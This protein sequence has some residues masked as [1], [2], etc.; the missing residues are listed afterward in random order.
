M[1]MGFLQ[2]LTWFTHR[3]SVRPTN[4]LSRTANTHTRIGIYQFSILLKV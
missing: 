1:Y 2:I 4:M 3:P